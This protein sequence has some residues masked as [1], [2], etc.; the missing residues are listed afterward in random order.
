MRKIHLETLQV[1]GYHSQG[2]CFRNSRF[3]IRRL[4]VRVLSGVVVDGLFCEVYLSNSAPLQ[5][6]AKPLPFVSL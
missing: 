2:R 4:Q 6:N 5:I 3:L 1:K